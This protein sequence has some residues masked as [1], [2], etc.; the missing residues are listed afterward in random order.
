MSEDCV[1][2]KIVNGEIPVEEFLYKDDNFVSFLDANPAVEGHALVVPKKHFDTFL[3]VEEDFLR[4]YLKAVQET[5]K[6]LIQKYGADGFNIILNNGEA[7]EQVV[8][9]V[10]FH[11]VPRKEGDN[12]RGEIYGKIISK[13]E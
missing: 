10:H 13:G 6:I 1:F 8:K 7:A 3:D 11:L 5:G 12:V 9:H 2:C 4:G